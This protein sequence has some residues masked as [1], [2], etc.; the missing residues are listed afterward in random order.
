M[1][2]LN[3]AVLHYAFHGLAES[4]RSER[5]RTA[6]IEHVLANQHALT[7]QFIDFV[8]KATFFQ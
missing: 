5:S 2:G 4:I 1:V 7:S 3:S 8:S 6:V